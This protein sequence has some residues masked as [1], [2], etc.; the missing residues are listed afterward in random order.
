MVSL[1]VVNI[2][3]LILKEL[4]KYD[5]WNTPLQVAEGLPVFTMDV[6]GK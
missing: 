5:C 4:M 2:S 3:S 6:H 1:P